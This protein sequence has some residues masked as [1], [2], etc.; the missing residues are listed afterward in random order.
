MFIYNIIIYI[1]R[2]I[3]RRS[4]NTFVSYCIDIFSWG[5]QTFLDTQ[6]WLLHDVW[7]HRGCLRALCY[8]QFVRFR[9]VGISWVLD[10][11]HGLYTFRKFFFE[12]IWSA[13]VSR[14]FHFSQAN[15]KSMSI[16]GPGSRFGGPPEKQ[17]KRQNRSDRLLFFW[18]EFRLEQAFNISAGLYI[19]YSRLF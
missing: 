15:C 6:L 2:Y 18:G 12:S 3:H 8:K 13:Q 17:A 19:I 16:L 1:Q 5:S 4:D 10:R 7:S 9:S 14:H 11:I